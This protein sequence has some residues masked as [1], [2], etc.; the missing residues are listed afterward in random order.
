MVEDTDNG[1]KLVKIKKQV[2]QN[3]NLRFEGRR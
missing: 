2:S 3:E 1:H